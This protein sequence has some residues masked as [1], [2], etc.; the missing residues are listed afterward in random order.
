MS[1]VKVCDLETEQPTLDCAMQEGRRASPVR[2]G[3]AMLGGRKKSPILLYRSSLSNLSNQ[4]SKIV[5][6]GFPAPSCS[7]S[8][9]TNAQYKICPKGVDTLATL[10]R[11]NNGR[12]FLRPASYVAA[13]R[14]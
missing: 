10:D 9:P 7:G 5:E 13:G 1:S 8:S 11:A 2:P 14:G 6:R 3:S 4:K 12:H